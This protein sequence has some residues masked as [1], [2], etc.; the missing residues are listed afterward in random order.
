MFD[1]FIGESTLT[2]CSDFQFPVETIA[3]P[4]K[5]IITHPRRNTNQKYLRRL[6]TNNTPMMIKNENN[7]INC[8]IHSNS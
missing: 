1:P 8:M 4:C 2:G 6:N 3:S 5:Y 7:E